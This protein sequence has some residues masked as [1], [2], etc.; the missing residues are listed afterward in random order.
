MDEGRMLL[1]VNPTARHGETEALLPVIEKLLA[2]LPHDTVL[3]EHVG[4]ATDIVAQAEGYD[5][6][7][8][9]GGDG[10]VHEIL[11]GLMRHPAGS[12]PILGLLPTGSGN[13]TRRMLGVS[14]DLAQ[15]ALELSTGRRRSFDVGVCNGVYFNNSFAA[16]L[17]AKVTAKA[18]EYK[19][20]KKRDGLWLYL[21]ALLHVLFN[22]LD[23][24]D[25]TLSFDGEE[26]ARV[27]TLILAATNGP[28]YGGGPA[29]RRPVRGVHDRPAVPP[30]G[31]VAP[32]VRDRGQAHEDEGRAHVPAHLGGHR[33]GRATAC[34]DRRR[35][36]ARA[37]LRDIDAA[38]RHHLHRPEGVGVSGLAPHFAPIIALIVA[39]AIGSIPWAYL[40]V[41]WVAGEDISAHGSGNIG[42]MNVKRTT[43]SWGW[44]AV[45]TL[46]DMSK[47][48]APALLAKAWVAGPG[49]DW[50]FI[51]RPWGETLRSV[52]SLWWANPVFYIPLAAVLGAVLGHN[53]SMWMAIAQRKFTRT[54]KGLATGAGALLA[55]DWRYF[56]IVVVVGLATIAISRYM[57]A[58]QVAAAVSLPVG[59]LALQSPDWWFALGMGVIVYWAHH[60][61]FIGMLKGHEPKFYTKDAM[62]P[63]G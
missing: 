26:P 63:R 62:G 18:V 30:G 14:T 12:R 41:K 25:V 7:V 58:G 51:V 40:I 37:P 56:A 11:N 17:D 16:G 13:D 29:R 55:Y 35:G 9:A 15:A 32:S 54:G 3:T 39:Y 1:V 52:D 28:T 31:A 27:T 44:F 21:T 33:V 48:F 8:A 49:L 34:S 46:A 36:P 6:V 2:S 45:A 42:A 19:V 50:T 61:R 59:A 60:K 20:T 57:M 47:G 10:T 38:G 4:H 23:P 53:Y 24:F 22:E 43:G 5:V